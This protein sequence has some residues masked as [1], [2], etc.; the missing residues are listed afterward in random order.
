MARFTLTVFLLL[1]SCVPALAATERF[2]V[3]DLTVMPP[4]F[5]QPEFELYSS[6]KLTVDNVNVWVEKDLGRYAPTPD[7]LEYLRL[8]VTVMIELER[9][10]FGRQPTPPNGNRDF[11][12][13]IASLPPYEK[14]GKKF[15]FDGFFNVFDQLTE[16]Q[17]LEQGQHSNERN[18][19]YVNAIHDVGTPY[20]H[21]VLAHEL[22][23][24]IT[25][26]QYNEE[27]NALDPWLNEMLGEAAMQLTSY[28]TDQAHVDAYR[29]HPEWPLAVNGYGL[30]YGG[31]SLFA[32]YLM[33]RFDQK[34]IGK[35]APATGNAFKRLEAV[36]G[37]DWN[38]LFEGYVRW[39]YEQ[40]PPSHFAA[41]ALAV[42]E[43]SDALSIGTTGIAFVSDLSVTAENF[44]ITAVPASCTGSRNM[45]RTAVLNGKNRAT[46]IWIES[47]PPC[48]S[49][50]GG[51]GYEKDAFRI[52]RL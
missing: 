14:N 35:L 25:H 23:H 51:Q 48:D 32:E 4:G 52:E 24:L 20:M 7:T 29:A 9:E 5:R 44:K 46:A 38:V 16:A 43:A 8:R 40:Q 31:A 45:L 36:Y 27:T 50:R 1:L 13:M 30:S 11:N 10:L 19:V 3:W 12:I 28:Y 42:R 17:A 49:Q 26:G 18:I 39:L 41:G 2:W 34:L 21:G 47:T 33:R 37:M 22:N 15:G 6:D